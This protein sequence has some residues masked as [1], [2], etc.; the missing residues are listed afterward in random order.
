M[1]QLLN[2]IHLTSNVISVFEDN[3]STIKMGNTLETNRSKHIDVRHYFIK[4]LIANNQVKLLYISTNEQIADML[5]KPL[6]AVKFQYFRRALN[7]FD[8]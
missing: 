5:T 1:Q 2:D 8:G 3:Q 6:P 4:D 7:L